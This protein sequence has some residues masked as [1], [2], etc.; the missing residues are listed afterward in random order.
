MK[1]QVSIVLRYALWATV[2]SAFLVA[3]ISCAV[4]STLATPSG[5]ASIDSYYETAATGVKV[6]E[7]T[8]KITNIG[9][10][11]IKTSCVSL[12]VGTSSHS[13]NM[14]SVY[15]ID[16]LAGQ[17]IFVTTTVSYENSSESTTSSGITINGQ[18]YE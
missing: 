13:Y 14:T 1:G 7:I 16:I 12:T 6:C 15:T 3:S 8:L 11:K 10:Q 9:S 5:Q 18:F 4:E 2:F 17:S